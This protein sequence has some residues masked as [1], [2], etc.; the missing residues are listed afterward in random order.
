MDTGLGIRDEDKPKLFKAFGKL[1]NNESSIMN[2]NGVGLGLL[3]SH[4]LA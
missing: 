3:I 1:S 4:Q 2:K